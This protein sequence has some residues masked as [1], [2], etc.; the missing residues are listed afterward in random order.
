MQLLS[1]ITII[2]F[3]RLLP[4]PLATH[5]LAQMGAEVIKV[6]SPK[7][8]DY[9]RSAGFKQIDGANPLFHQLNHNKELREIDYNEAFGKAAILELA[10]NAD[11]LI[12]Q[13]RPGAMESWGLGYEN[14]KEV[15]P[16]LIYVSITGYGQ[17]G[18]YHQEAGH[19]FN[20]LAYSGIMSLIKDDQ[21]K[22]VV[23][24]TQF[25]DIGGAYMA[26]IALQGAL[27]QKARTGQGSYVDLALCDSMLPFLAVPFG[28]HSEGYDY[29]MFNIIN[30]KTAVNYAAYQCEDGKWLSVA[31]MEIKF[32]N[33]LCEAIDRL[34]WQR[35][36][37]LELMNISF[38]KGEI[39][40]LFATRPRDEWIELLQGKDV[41]VA[42]ILEIEELEV[43][44]YHQEKASFETIETPNGSELRGISLPFRL[45]E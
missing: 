36:H 7:R 23:P 3:T 16:G 40:S 43:H 33:Q 19:D 10:Q 27:L 44:P 39:E 22:P 38:P 32:W 17:E 8:K 18:R 2:D 42:P 45:R 24:D 6:E 4:G 28:F 26:V 25:A 14:L 41:C 1:G 13:F 15:N 9:A 35:K 34:D 31:A 37:Q 5:L 11:V 21:G 20:Y 12:E 30:G 29:R